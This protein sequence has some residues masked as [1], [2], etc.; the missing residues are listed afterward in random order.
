MTI[1]NITQRFYNF[2]EDVK[3][4]KQKEKIIRYCMYEF[5]EIDKEHK[6]LSDTRKIQIALDYVI[7]YVIGKDNYI[8]LCTNI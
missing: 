7:T 1:S 5:I 4:K 3:D 8:C 6:C 2:F